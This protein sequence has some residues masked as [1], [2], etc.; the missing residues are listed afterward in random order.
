MALTNT[1]VK[2]AVEG[3]HRVKYVDITFDSSYATG[4]EALVAADVG[5][6]KIVHVGVGTGNV[7]TVFYLSQFDYTNNKL[8]TFT[9][10][11]QTASTTDLSALTV[12]VRIA[13]Y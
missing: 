4:G 6:S 12:R 9:A 13:G 10:G 5:L 11:A 2:H 3:A 7:T 1:V 8:L